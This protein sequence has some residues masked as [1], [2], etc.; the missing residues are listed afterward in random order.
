MGPSTSS[1]P[2]PSND[3][4]GGG[5]E[6]RIAVDDDDDDDDDD[7]PLIPF[8]CPAPQLLFARICVRF[9]GKSALASL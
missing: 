1:G 3:D 5:A 4:E 7:K 8:C 6:A 2:K 9:F